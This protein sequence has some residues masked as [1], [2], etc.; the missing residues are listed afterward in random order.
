M[1][2]NTFQIP[3]TDT[4]ISDI[5]QNNDGYYILNTPDKIVRWIN[6]QFEEQSIAGANIPGHPPILHTINFTKCIISTSEINNCSSMSLHDIAGKIDCICKSNKHYNNKTIF[7]QEVLENI[8]FYDCIINNGFFQQ[9]KFHKDVIIIKSKFNRGTWDN[10]EFIGN[11]IIQDSKL[12]ISGISFSTFHGTVSFSHSSISGIEFSFFKNQYKSDVTFNKVHFFIENRNS[13]SKQPHINFNHSSFDGILLLIDIKWP[14]DCWF[15]YCSFKDSIF[16]TNNNTNHGIFF[17]R[18]VFENEFILHYYSDTSS[19]LKPRINHLS[20]SFAYIYNRI[21]IENHN[22]TS[23]Q[24]NY[25]TILNNGVLHLS[26]SYIT[27]CNMTS[28]YNRG[29]LFFQSNSISNITLENV[30]N[31]GI[32]ELENT[33]IDIRNITNRKTARILKDS[34]YKNNNIIDG[35]RYKYLE[36]ELYR[37]EGNI[38]F[39]DQ[40]ILFFQK[41]SNTYGTNFLRGIYFTMISAA[42]FFWLINYFGTEKQIFELGLNFYGFGEIWKKYLDVLNVLNFRTKLNDVELNAIGETLFLIAKIFIAYGMY[43][44]VSAFRKYSKK[45]Q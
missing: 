29:I 32:V 15:Y 35:L 38:S 6:Y 36:L 25:V 43:Q 4:D 11:L 40:I 45:Q 21:H 34:A 2:K 10:C 9:T 8:R 13:T 42:I 17:N 5:D 3:R 23:L 33:Y 22:I 16:L 44:T 26:N 12:N 18:S 37:K 41:Y 20:L 31:I 24:A 30:M 28:I 1:G 14:C 19:A 39:T 27:T 7:H